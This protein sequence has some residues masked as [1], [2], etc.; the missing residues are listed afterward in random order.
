[1]NYPLTLTL[2]LQGREDHYGHWDF[3]LDLA[4]EP[5]N[6]TLRED[7]DFGVAATAD[8]PISLTKN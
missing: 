7:R 8:G 5:C 3:E 6:L 1:V 4:F 2:S